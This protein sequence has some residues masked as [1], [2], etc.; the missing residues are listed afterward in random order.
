MK[1]TVSIRGINIGTGMP[2][3][4]VSLIG[5]DN[6]ELNQEIEHLKNMKVDIA[7]W[8][9]DHYREIEKIEK[10]EEALRVIRT[11]WGDKPLLA[12]FRSKKEGGEQ[13]VS[14][15]YY[16]KLNKS[17]IDTGMADLVDVELFSEEKTVKKLMEYAHQKNVKVIMSNHDFD[18]TPNKEEI[19]DRLCK[20]QQM[21]ADILKIA[22]MPQNTE[23]VL[24]L[25]GATNEMVTKHA[26]RPVVTMAMGKLGL[27]SRLSGEIFGSA[28]TFGAAQIA[29]APGQIS[30]KEL[31][32]IL[33][34]M[35][36]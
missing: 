13:E 12:T 31:R 1:N 9:M 35:H 36:Q 26:N 11:E 21:D 27:V 15:E 3:I 29:S 2:K 4:C 8:R 14:Q 5:K 17:V 33:E 34:V 24:T 16:I 18:K 22:V 6:N 20:M 32:N 25:L 23:D 7:E 30:A 10:V 28:I 19:V